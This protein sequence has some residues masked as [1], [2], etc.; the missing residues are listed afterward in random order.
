[1]VD[2][3]RPQIDPDGIGADR[4]LRLLIGCAFQ[5]QLDEI[6]R[7]FCIGSSGSRTG[8]RASD[9]ARILDVVIQ[10]MFD[11]RILPIDAGRQAIILPEEY[12]C[13]PL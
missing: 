4:V 11:H 12:A 2:G 5:G 3:R 13:M 6:A 7:A 8:S 10:A 9:E 1:M